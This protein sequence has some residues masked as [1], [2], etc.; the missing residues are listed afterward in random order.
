M[1]VVFNDSFEVEAIHDEKRVVKKYVENV[2]NTSK[3]Q[4]SIIKI[5]KKDV[6][7]IKNKDDLYLV[8]YA[9]TYIQSCYIDYLEICDTKI[10]EDE[11]YALDILCRIIETRRLNKKDTK[12]LEKAILILD[13]ISDIDASYT[14]DEKQLREMKM[15]VESMKHLMDYDE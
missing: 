9:D 15:E 8:R 2:Y 3:K 10:Y 6:K 1:Y 11:R 5:K 12:V 14:P 7:K 13:R 4:L